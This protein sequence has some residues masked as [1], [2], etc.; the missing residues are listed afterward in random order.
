MIGIVVIIFGFLFSGL[1]SGIETGSYS[2]NRI[3]LKRKVLERNIQAN[4]LNKLISSPYKFIFMVLIGNNI[5]IYVLSSQVTNIYIQN[6]YNSNQIIFGFI[7]WNADIIATLTLILP[8]FLFAEILPKNIFRI[9]ADH[10]MYPLSF[11]IK[12]FSIMFIPL[13]WPLENFFKFIIKDSS[14]NLSAIFYKVSPNTF[15]KEL[16]LL[17]KNEVIPKF[18]TGM[19]ENVIDMHK[20]PI[21]SLKTYFNKVYLVDIDSEVSDVKKIMKTNRC[22]EVFVTKDKKIIGFISIHDFFER[23]FCDSDSIKKIMKDF[24]KLESHRSLK[25]A[26]YR[27]KNSS[28]NTAVIFDKNNNCIG[29]ISMDDILRFIFNNK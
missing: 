3:K 1:F 27:I 13:T 18:Q 12:V 24:L 20:I 11:L 14:E 4:R 25:A 16:N 9:F 19:I 7:P 8:V 17:K 21:H 6:G 2:I 23:N 26:F 5:A 22:R 29:S 28:M 10:L 15:K